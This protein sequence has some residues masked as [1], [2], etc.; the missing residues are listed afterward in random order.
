MMPPLNG[1]RVVSLAVNIPGPVAAATLRE[2]GA[3][4]IKVEPPSGDPLAVGSP[5]WY[6]E[7]VSDMQIL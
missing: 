1:V 4:V 6:Q 3:S 7:L 5:A 2:L